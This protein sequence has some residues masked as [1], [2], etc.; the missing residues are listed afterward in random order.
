MV[1][2]RVGSYFL[3]LEGGTLLFPHLLLSDPKC[4]S[5]PYTG[6]LR[7]M[8]RGNNRLRD[9]SWA[10]ERMIVRGGEGYSCVRHTQSPVKGRNFDDP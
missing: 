10:R 7:G 3:V 6:E 4:S 2:G 1:H 5:S 9:G 8:G